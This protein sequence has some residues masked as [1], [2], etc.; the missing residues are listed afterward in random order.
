MSMISGSGAMDVAFAISAAD[1]SAIPEVGLNAGEARAA[2]LLAQRLFQKKTPMQLLG[3]Y[4]DGLQ[5]MQDLGIAIP[6]ALNRIRTVVGWPRVGV[7]AIANR[8]KLEGFRFPGQTTTDDDVWSIWQANNL[9]SESHL[10]HL[11]A[12]IFGRAYIIVGPGDD[13]TFGMP[14]ITAESPLNMAA[15]WDTRTRKCTAAFQI[16]ISNDFTSDLY[17]Q[18]ICSLY[19]PNATI[20]MTRQ[21]ISAGSMTTQGAS[22]NQW[23]IVSRDDHNLGFV[24]VVRM[25]NR[26]RLGDRDGMSEIT[27]EWRNTTDSACRT[28]LGMEIAREF[29]AAP[30][31]YI[32]GASEDQFQKADGTPTSAWDTYMSKV[33]AIERDED[34]N[35][36]TVSEFKASDPKAFT[37]IIDTYAKIMSGEMGVP[38]HFLG[39]FAAGNPASADAIRSGYEELTI[40]SLNKHIQF[41][42]AWE[43]AM[44]LALRMGNMSVPDDAYR[45][46][47][48]WA[49]PSPKTPGATAQAI[50]QQISSGALPATSDVTLRHL[51]YSPNERRQIEI[52]RSKDEGAAFLAE[53]A[54]SL[55]AKIAR[56]DKSLS[57]DIT[58]GDTVPG[59]VG[60]PI[61]APAAPP[62]K[63][64]SK[65]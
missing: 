45:M 42:E 59:T 40:R 51:G 25:A 3:Y 63:P 36:P 54:H 20:N 22:K 19:L 13:S 64:T 38:P 41:G 14:L 30:R 8:C 47:S 32:L 15:L 58:A 7:D 31:R 18:E 11:D 4:Y 61:P 10:A 46:E 17:G 2:G 55:T 35:L 50:F 56:V 49:D 53:L 34:G 60:E 29:Y 1:V 39:I 43:E 6:P 26:T 44:R 21:S 37:E 62:G 65:P 16:F 48:D 27:P 9:D 12:L 5:K 24:P 23:Q 57:A 28:L 33:W 52:D